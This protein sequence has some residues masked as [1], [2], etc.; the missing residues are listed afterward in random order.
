MTFWR[1]FD[2]I[3]QL[4]GVEFLIWSSCDEDGRTD[5][6]KGIDIKVIQKF[7]HTRKKISKLI[8]LKT[9]ILAVKTLKYKLII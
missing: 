2:I 8:I 1:F 3:Y 9:N 7:S 6:V 5:K 4:Q